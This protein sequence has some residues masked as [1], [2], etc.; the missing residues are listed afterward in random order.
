MTETRRE[1]I[2]KSGPHSGQ[3]LVAESDEKESMIAS[4]YKQVGS[5]RQFVAD[6]WFET[7]QEMQEAFEEM[8][9]HVE[10]LPEQ[11][12]PELPADHVP[13][14]GISPTD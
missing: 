14:P 4:L 8:G 1:A 5:Q 7:F 2:I 3:T 13:L 9:W 10:W 11:P 6:Y 12:P